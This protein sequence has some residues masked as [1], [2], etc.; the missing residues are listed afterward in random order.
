MSLPFYLLCFVLLQQNPAVNAVSQ[1]KLNSKIQQLENLHNQEIEILRHQVQQK[2]AN[3]GK[4][5]E[6]TLTKRVQ[7]AQTDLITTG[8]EDTSSRLKQA[9]ASNSE[10]QTLRTA[11]ERAKQTGS[12]E[13]LARAADA[14][15]ELATK[16]K[17]LISVVLKTLK[18]GATVKYQTFGERIRKEPAHTVGDLTDTNITLPLGYYYIWAERSQKPTSDTETLYTVQNNPTPVT[19]NEQ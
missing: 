8:A 16:Y 2:P 14:Q 13:D 9:G 19:L 17:L 15:T 3:A 4:L 12:P 5:L 10:L 1:A 6:A 18:S 7:N 11:N